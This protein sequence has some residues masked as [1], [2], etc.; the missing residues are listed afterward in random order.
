MPSLE[1]LPDF[2]V[3]YKLFA[4]DNTVAPDVALSPQKFAKSFDVLALSPS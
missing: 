2:K 3:I 1:L 4:V